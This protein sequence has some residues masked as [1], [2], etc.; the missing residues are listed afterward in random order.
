LPSS[1]RTTVAPSRNSCAATSRAMTASSDGHRGAA[2]SCFK[3]SASAGALHIVSEAECTAH[4]EFATGVRNSVRQGFRTRLGRSVSLLRASPV[5]GGARASKCTH[6]PAAR[7]RTSPLLQPRLN[8][9]LEENTMHT[10]RNVIHVFN[11]SRLT[12]YQFSYDIALHIAEA[13]KMSG[14]ISTNVT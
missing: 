6:A 14:S 11:I 8:C 12:N 4:V 9:I 3:G 13:C 10:V 1:S 5:E 7:R 2:P